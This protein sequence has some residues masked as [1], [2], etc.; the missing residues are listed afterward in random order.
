VFLGR[1][2]DWERR[3]RERADVARAAAASASATA[4]KTRNEKSSPAPLRPKS[5]ANA[6]SRLSTT[7]LEEKIESIQNE[8]RDIDQQMMDQGIYSDFL[9]W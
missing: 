9:R 8:I 3:Q 6:L 1:Y 7:T 2:S 5:T 4:Q